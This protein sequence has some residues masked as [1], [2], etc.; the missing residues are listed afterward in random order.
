MTLN[1]TKRRSPEIGILAAAIEREQMDRS[2][3]VREHASVVRRSRS[4]ALHRRRRDLRPPLG[5]AETKKTRGGHLVPAILVAIY[6]R[7]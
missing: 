2:T 6:F 4:T 7:T 5:E 1:E 3:S